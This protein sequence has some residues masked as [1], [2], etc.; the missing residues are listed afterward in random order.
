MKKAVQMQTKKQQGF[1]LIEII[2][3]LIVLG[4]LSALAV[5]RYMNVTTEA[6][7]ASA[8]QAIAETMSRLNQGS[9]SHIL[10]NDGVAPT[11]AEAVTAAGGAALTVGDYT[12]AN[13]ASGDTVTITATGV[14]GTPA[15]GGSGSATWV[16]PQ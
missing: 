13:V 11:G 10:N 12:V 3:V 9:A 5:P 14:S 8:N 15:D 7:N 6:K 4:V 1:T 16:A 2:A